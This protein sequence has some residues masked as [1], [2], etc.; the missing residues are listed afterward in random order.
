MGEL[1]DAKGL[2]VAI[3]VCERNNLFGGAR[4]P[5]GTDG[6]LGILTGRGLGLTGGFFV[7]SFVPDE[8]EE[9]G[10][11][12]L[13]FSLFPDDRLAFRPREAKNPPAL[14]E[15]VG[16]ATDRIEEVGVPPVRGS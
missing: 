1:F 12:V 10:L 9:T 5:P 14:E 11:A 16:G 13:G 4:G 8:E 15:G 3:I 7:R 6:L 2:L